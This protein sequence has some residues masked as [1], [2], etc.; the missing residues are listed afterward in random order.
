MMM[1]IYNDA[2]DLDDGIIGDFSF[3][4]SNMCFYI[5]L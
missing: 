1:Q 4:S 5:F 2:F 3:V